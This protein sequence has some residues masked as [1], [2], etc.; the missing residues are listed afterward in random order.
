VARAGKDRNTT[1][2][3]VC[4]T[5]LGKTMTDLAKEADVRHLAHASDTVH[6]SRNHNRVLRVLIGWGIPVKYL[7]L[8]KG[9]RMEEEA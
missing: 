8:P 4:M 6:G 9:F 3:K 7:D 2:I 5:R 1:E